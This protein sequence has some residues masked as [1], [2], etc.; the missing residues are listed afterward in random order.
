MDPSEWVDRGDFPSPN[1]QEVDGDWTDHE[2]R[3][4]PLF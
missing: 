1:D 2:V 4:G 3:P